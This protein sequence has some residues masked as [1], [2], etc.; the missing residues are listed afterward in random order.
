MIPA[1]LYGNGDKAVNLA[2]EPAIVKRILLSPHGNNSVFALRVEGGESVE[3]VRIV[4]FQ[5]DPVKRTLVHCDF[6]R[7]DPAKTLK[8]RVPLRLVGV[9][10]ATKLGAKSR[11]V[12]RW[13]K[14]ACLP[15]VIPEAIE[16]DQTPLEPSEAIRLSAV[17][18]PEGV[19]LIYRDNAPVIVATSVAASLAMDAA[20]DAEEA[21]AEETEA[22]D[23]DEEEVTEGEE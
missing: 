15:G 7:L 12:T 17:V 22:T 14:V 21:G 9:S 20:L 23:G 19:E 5:K 18:A 3:H 13:V 16:V 1:V 10:N 8:V 2:V 6:Q 4:S 11:F